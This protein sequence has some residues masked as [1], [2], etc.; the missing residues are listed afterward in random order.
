MRED[1]APITIDQLEVLVAIA[2]HGS[3]SA[4]AR[5]LN[6]VQSA[7]SYAVATL[8][9][10]L[11]VTLFDRSERKPQLT[12]AGKAI[13]ADGRAALRDIDKLKARARSIAAGTEPFVAIAVS[14]M[15]PMPE[16]VAAID[17][18]RAEF[19]ETRL[20]LHTEALGGVAGL[21]LDGTCVVGVSEPVPKPQSALELQPLGAVQMIHV[22]SARHTLASISAP[23]RRELEEHVQ[24]VL[25]DR[26]RLTE[27]LNFGVLGGP[28]WRV[29]DLGT[30]L[31]FLEAGFGWGG[32]PAH[33]VQTGLERGT[34]ARIQSAEPGLLSHEVPLYAAHRISAPPGPA[35]RWLM[36]RL[37]SCSGLRP[38]P[39]RSKK[40]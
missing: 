17:A 14:A 16:L 7:V 23:T 30:K 9:R 33:L 13:L 20:E 24:I 2:E 22:V 34:L 26:S 25:S 28:T 8:E 12:E 38:P 32:M 1:D 15:F 10:Q 18:F 36:E 5:A 31:A 27:G 6:R 21:V 29:A 39:K 3:F 35:A 11:G 4:A 19:R 40:R 37:A